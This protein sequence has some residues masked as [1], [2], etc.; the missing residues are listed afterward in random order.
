MASRFSSR[1]MLPNDGEITSMSLQG[2]SIRV[3]NRMRTVRS[4]DGILYSF[5][6]EGNSEASFDVPLGTDESSSISPTITMSQGSN[7][8]R[9]A[10]KRVMMDHADK[11]LQ[12][13]PRE[14]FLHLPF[15]SRALPMTVE[16]EEK[17]NTFRAERYQPI[18]PSHYFVESK[19]LHS[20]CKI[21]R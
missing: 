13:A 18:Y 5:G 3:L 6:N 1:R 10:E 4:D 21:K 11:M 2:T 20:M 17:L 9:N 12:N 7:N 19:H 8:E 16:V 14:P 15:Q